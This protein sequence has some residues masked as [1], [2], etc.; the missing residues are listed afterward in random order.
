M[1]KLVEILAKELGEWPVKAVCMC[2]DKD[3][4]IWPCN[5]DHDLSYD[6]SRWT[7]DEGFLIGEDIIPGA[8]L[9]T[10]HA[11]AIVTRE[12]WQ[13]ERERAVTGQ[14]VNGDAGAKDWRLTESPTLHCQSV[15]RV[16]RSED[17]RATRD[18]I[19]TIDATI[20]AMTAERAELVSK[21][22]GE[23][24]ALIAVVAAEQ[25][26]DMSDPKT[27]RVGD[28][29]LACGN[30]GG[31]SFAGQ[32]VKILAVCD[33]GGFEVATAAEPNYGW[34]FA[35]HEVETD[36]KFHSRPTA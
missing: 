21:L 31:F 20:E 16:Y 30:C 3:K 32:V 26:E 23:G 5:D 8:E 18:R 12:M 9:A 15:G 19:Y 7:A 13:A 34:F 14:G 1:A 10:D 27:W 22:A 35:D 29:L 2:Q 11:T 25:V 6:G 33:D 4:E 36:L 24:F 17:P 28:N